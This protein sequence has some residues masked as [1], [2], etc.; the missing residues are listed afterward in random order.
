MTSDLLE[1]IRREGT[2]EDAE[3]GRHPLSLEIDAREERF[4]R[5]LIAADPTI[6]RTLEIGLARNTSRQHRQERKHNK[7][8]GVVPRQT[9]R[10]CRHGIQPQ[11]ETNLSPGA[12][13]RQKPQRLLNTP[14]HRPNRPSCSIFRMRNRNS[15]MHHRLVD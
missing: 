4:L 14:T 13:L 6:R 15:Q 5:E 12:T 7:S 2:V 8:A 3:G 1:R 11:H 9:E 10:F